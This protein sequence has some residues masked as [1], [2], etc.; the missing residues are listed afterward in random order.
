[1]ASPGGHSEES[2]PEREQGALLERESALQAISDALR[3]ACGGESQA[4]F[5]VAEP[6]LGKTTLLAEASAMA[7]RSDVAFDVVLAGCSEIEAALP[8]GLLSRVTES[9][10]SAQA[11]ATPLR[12]AAP[13][14]LRAKQVASGPGSAEAR[15]EHYLDFMTLMRS[16]AATPLLVAVDDFQWA[17]PD[18]VELLAIG[19]R[20]FTSLPIAFVAALRPWPAGA[21]E[22]ARL[23]ASEGFAVLEHLAPLSGEAS[24]ELLA[25]NMCVVVPEDVAERAVE[26]C[27]GN[28]LLL[29]ELAAAWLRHDPDLPRA[30]FRFVTDRIYLPRFAGVG[31]EAVRWARAASVLGTRFRVD[32]ADELAGQAGERGLA[33]LEALCRAGLL[34]GEPLGYAAF[35]HPLFREALYE[36]MPSPVR[37]AMHAQAFRVLQ[38]LGAPAAEA[39]AHV[40][41]AGMRADR[42]GW[43][44]LLEAGRGALRVG[45]LRTAVGHLRDALELA[46]SAA[47]LSMH[48]ELAQAELA[49]GEI[50]DAASR[51]QAII[52]GHAFARAPLADADR[53]SVL[54]ILAQVLLGAGSLG[55]AKRRSEEA[56]E[57]ALRTDPG[58]ACAILLDC[59]FL[60][61]IF[62]GPRAT[63]STTRR[64]LTMI[65]EHGVVDADLT[66]AALTADAY[67]AFLEGDPY[68][69][70]DVGA[71]ARAA[72][73]KPEP[74]RQ[75]VPWFWDVCFGYALLAKY[76]E[77]FEDE[78]AV[79][80]SIAG[81]AMSEGAM[82]T[83]EGYV[84]NHADAM[85][86]TGHLEEAH[87][88]LRS[89]TEMSDIAR[90]VGTHASV[91]MA[92]LC[93][94]L[95]RDE[96]STMWFERVEAAAEALG[97]P[98][99]LQL[100][101]L[102]L[103][104]R[105]HLQ[106]GHVREAVLAARLAGSLADR[107][108][109]IEPCVVPWHSPAIE[110]LAGA[111]EL[112]ELDRL[113]SV[114]EERCEPLG[115]RAPRVTAAAGRALL[116]WRRGDIEGASTR[117][118]E[119]LE[120]CADLGMP[121]V[122]LETRIAYG[123]FL[124]L[125]GHADSAKK[126]LRQAVSLAEPIGAIRLLRLASAELASAGG[127]RRRD[128]PR[129]TPSAQERRV[130]SLAAAGLTNKQIGERLFISPKT[131]DHHLSSVYAKLG[132]GSRRALMLSWSEH[133]HD[134]YELS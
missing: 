28:P 124:R 57:I 116:A 6:G 103:S 109:I 90:A 35:V 129:T 23:L 79:H 4:L 93:Q 31:A 130:A 26:A 8:F 89:A 37:E 105:S 18:S 131:V 99:Y 107:T 67:L 112:D 100:W 98:P 84:V 42:S 96:E 114:L 66:L 51:L 38:G 106:S 117:Y 12:A 30:S 20:R 81:R 113:L 2:D 101:L 3:A 29:S 85:W 83:Y 21:F 39:A 56:A 40:R 22:Q 55:E 45:A 64:V 53:V 115:C 19:C 102:F 91:G 17:D 24:R 75:Q 86:R 61:W 121:L 13:G 120:L 11:P 70:D 10:D 27:A 32:V 87:E 111:G 34:R 127:R 118:N 69:V 123:R 15:V 128:A 65:E 132:I 126:L 7:A 108:G 62:E 44:V 54:R 68:G 46:G 71:A 9:L 48:L 16:R 74:A 72:M 41:A 92:H 119:A 25:R 104:C 33:S 82:L 14:S 49:V 76:A 5:V 43:R 73:E 58:L 94:E 134:E 110:A 1:M 122:E 80:A 78:D 97:Q 95:G 59:T 50:P 133:V 36:D 47:P 88:L 125:T 60:G 52:D 77:R 63:R